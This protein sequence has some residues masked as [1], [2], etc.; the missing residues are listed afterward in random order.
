MWELY[1]G[2][3]ETAKD[4][5]SQ[6]PGPLHGVV[7]FFLLRVVAAAVGGAVGVQVVLFRTDF[8]M[9]SVAMPATV[10]DPRAPLPAPV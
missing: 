8:R 9:L 2:L 4:R 3:R 6:S 7:Q 10:I 1:C 5:V